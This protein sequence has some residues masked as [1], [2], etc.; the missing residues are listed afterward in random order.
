[1]AVYGKLVI[2][3]IPRNNPPAEALTLNTIFTSD[4]M[5]TKLTG[6]IS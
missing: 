4:F 5:N 1:L 2:I 6:S 3:R